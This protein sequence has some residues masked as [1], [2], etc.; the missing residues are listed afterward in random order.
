MSDMENQVQNST[1]RP[2]R[3][4]HFV[5]CPLEGGVPVVLYLGKSEVEPARSKFSRIDGPFRT[6]SDAVA[7][8]A[9]IETPTREGL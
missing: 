9:H 8:I 3:K 2:P 5:G 6:K 4:R 1:L 7:H